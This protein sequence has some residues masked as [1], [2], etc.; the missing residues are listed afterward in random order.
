[1]PVPTSTDDLLELLRKSD[2]VA[3]ARL[4]SFLSEYGDR[5][6]RTPRDLIKSLI[7]HALITQF[8]G[9]QL[10]Q[11][12][13]RGFTLGRY[14]VL[15]R[16]GSG[17]MGT[18][19]LC[20]HQMVGRKVAVKVLPTSQADNPASLGRFYREAR[21]AGV[22]DHPNLVKAHD[23][24]Q[25]GGLHFLVM[26]YVDGTSL[27]ALI[28]RFGPLAVPRAVEYARQAAVG[29]AHA[30]ASGLVH[31]DVKPANIMLE[32]NGMIRVLDLGLARFFNDHTDQLTVKY[33]DKHV[34]GTA[35]YVSPE[36]ALNSHDVDTRTD[37]YSL[38][39]TLYFC[40]TGQPPFPDGKV[41]QKLIWHQVR[42]PVPVEKLR[43]DVPPA[44]AAVVAKMMAKDREDRY[45]TPA[46]AAA[47]LEA[48]C[49][50]S[51][52]RPPEEEMPRLCPAAL[53]AGNA[54]T[55]TH[56]VG[57]GRRVT[58]RGVAVM[59]SDRMGALERDA[60][61]G[62][63]ATPLTLGKSPTKTEYPRPRPVPRE[64]DPNYVPRAE[65]NWLGTLLLLFVLALAGAG[66]GVALSLWR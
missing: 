42:N 33:D 3:P 64:L 34:L 26:D 55:G 14:R 32:R 7:N 43:P 20:A 54:S 56:K 58:G 39:C 47:A 22:L 9:D 37:I 10:L 1:M 51:V 16:I 52:G 6:P 4:E 35:D 2:L 50:E 11:G 46:E 18:V 44:V 49:V 21:A 59:D 48:L 25:D 24:D 60:S 15:E 17:G 28:A 8:Q 31:R 61:A 41:A 27:Q 38:G 30:F 63:M 13:W 40:L 66:V 23:I 5:L 19:Y 36:Q 57:A 12:K 53:A 29:L 65:A 45:Q 62:D